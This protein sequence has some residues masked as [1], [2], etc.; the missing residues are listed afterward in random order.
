MAKADIAAGRAFVSL[1]VKGTAFTKGLAK[2]RKELQEF[3]SGI[4]GIGASVAGM[5]AAITGSLTGALIQFSNVGDALDKIALRTGFS[6][7]AISELGFAAEQSGGTMEDVE[8]SI[9]RMSRNIGGIGPESIKTT[10]TLEKLG[11]SLES[12]QAMSPE[13]Q[14]QSIAERI[15]EI[16]DPTQRAA[17]AMA[18]F[19]E[20]GRMLLPMFKDVAALRAEARE[21]GLSPSPESI[22]AAAQINDAIN[23]VRRVIGAAIFEIGSSIAPMAQDVLAGFLQV[24]S[25]V[26]KFIAENRALIVVAA[27]VGT[28]VTIVGSAIV[29]VGTGFIGA[30]LA[31]SG[32]LSVVS[33]FTAAFGLVATIVSTVAAGVGLLLTP[34]GLL[35]TG[36]GVI[37]AKALAAST[38]GVDF[39]NSWDA[40]R[41]TL[42]AVTAAAQRA[43]GV[44][45]T[46]LAVGDYS[47]AWQGA[48]AGMKLAIAEGMDDAYKMFAEFFKNL[49]QMAKN[50]AKDFAFDVAS[51]MSIRGG[52]A[53]LSGA[54]RSGGLFSGLTIDTDKMKAEAEAELARLEAELAARE[55][56][57]G[58]QGKEAAASDSLLSDAKTELA[59][60]AD[61]AANA[62]DRETQ[63]IRQQI[64]ALREGEDAAERMRLKNEGLTSDQIENIMSLRA[65][66]KALELDRRKNQMQVDAVAKIGDAMIEAGKAPAEALA[67]EKKQIQDLLNVGFIDDETAKSAAQDAELRALQREL[68]GTVAAERTRLGLDKQQ[69]NAKLPTASVAT[70]NLTALASMAQSGGKN[71]QVAAIN[72]VEK[73]GA[74][75]VEKLERLILEVGKLGLF[76]P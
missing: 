61:E 15:G 8:G 26:R 17:A 51:A 25:G 6:A 65:Q 46:A 5:G 64:A 38:A 62:F 56:E 53:S 42:G 23:R 1:Y 54:S 68:D 20:N 63:A 36:L 35:A 50:F 29:A 22:A 41:S 40:I 43:G 4:V 73:I 72:K 31:I 18:I 45:T 11:L 69:A 7:A 52:G 27:K 9:R 76:H 70:N 16:E 49:M 34:V 60:S 74:K 12:I 66:E 21:L 33:A 3:G 59:E 10:E 32:V 67:A 47:I 71:L 2:A 28:V 19:G 37:A 30:G 55:V 48:M 13:D 14:Y 75:Q 39:R 58:A 24:V 44:I 57:R